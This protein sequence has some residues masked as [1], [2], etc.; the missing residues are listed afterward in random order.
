MK[1][2]PLAHLQFHTIKFINLLRFNGFIGGV[3][4]IACGW[5]FRLLNIVE[6]VICTYFSTFG[7]KRVLTS[8]AFFKRFC[9]QM[10]MYFFSNL[11]LYIIIL[12]SINIEIY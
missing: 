4:P 12:I 6:F 7:L 5:A 10:S 9:R 2:G 11:F 8:I 3:F 1:S